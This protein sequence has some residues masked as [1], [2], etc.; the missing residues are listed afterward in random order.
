MLESR[1]LLLVMWMMLLLLLLAEAAM[2]VVAQWQ[3]GC[4]LVWTRARLQLGHERLAASRSWPR[5]FVSGLTQHESSTCDA[6]PPRTHIKFPVRSTTIQTVHVSFTL[7]SIPAQYLMLV[8]LL[9]LLRLEFASFVRRPCEL[10]KTTPV[11]GRAVSRAVS[12]ACDPQQP[13]T[14]SM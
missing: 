14:R 7:S 10:K 6:T 9:S 13:V 4:Q 8:L 2:V 12:K 5:K 3:S 1:L 11:M